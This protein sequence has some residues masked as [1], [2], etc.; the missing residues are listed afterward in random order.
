[1]S[2]NLNQPEGKR[3]LWWPRCRWEEKN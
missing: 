2:L 3:L 1:M